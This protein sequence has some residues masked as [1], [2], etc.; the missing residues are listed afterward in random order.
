HVVLTAEGVDFF[1]RACAGRGGLALPRDGGA[2]WE[3]SN[4]HR[5]MRAASARAGIDPPINFHALR[6]TWA[7]LAV[8]NNTPLMVVARNLGHRDT[9]MVEK[10]YAHLAPNYVA[11]AIRAGA[12][13]FGIEPPG[14]VAPLRPTRENARK[15]RGN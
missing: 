7:S 4:Q 9:R 12:P 6:H 3:P 2:A 14:N 10:Y 1:R 5:L 15:N 11:D 13:R 8:M